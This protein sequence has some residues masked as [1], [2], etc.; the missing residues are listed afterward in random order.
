MG[1]RFRLRYLLNPGKALDVNLVLGLAVLL[2]LLLENAGA[3]LLRLV[4]LLL[5]SKLLTLRVLSTG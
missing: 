4:L 1:S 3:L 5:R 2:A